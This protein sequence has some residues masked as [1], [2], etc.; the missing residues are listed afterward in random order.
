MSYYPHVIGLGEEVDDNY[1][2]RAQRWGNTTACIDTNFPGRRF[3]QHEIDTIA[4]VKYAVES[5]AGKMISDAKTAQGYYQA[6]VDALKNEG[7]ISAGGDILRMVWSGS[8][9]LPD[10]TISNR[11]NGFQVLRKVSEEHTAL[12]GDLGFLMFYAPNTAGAQQVCAQKQN[13]QNQLNKILDQI[14]SL[15]RF[16]SDTEDRRVSVL[17][18]LVGVLL[19]LLEGFMAILNAA[20]NVIGAVFNAL[21]STAGFLAQHPN[22]GMIALGVVA[23]GF[24]LIYFRNFLPIGRFL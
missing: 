22:I 12:N 17:T 1:G 2:A 21:V 3:T 4:K 8:E 5:N 14:A 9:P 18:N 20:I 13:I 6:A 16:I 24:G 23:V 11:D 10:A 7:W 19:N 15:N